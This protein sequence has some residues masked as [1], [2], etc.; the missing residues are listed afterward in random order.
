[1]LKIAYFV[2]QI[3]LFLPFRNQQQRMNTNS[4]SK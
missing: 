4:L 3:Y 1:M 2:H